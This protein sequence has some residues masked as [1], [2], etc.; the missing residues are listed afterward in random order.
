MQ[1]REAQRVKEALEPAKPPATKLRPRDARKAWV[2]AGLEQSG[3]GLKDP[4]T[5]RHGWGYCVLQRLRPPGG[6]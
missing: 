6:A 2:R 4:T 5:L 1:S 3:G